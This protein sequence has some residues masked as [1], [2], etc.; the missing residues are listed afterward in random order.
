M[1]IIRS[2]IHVITN[3]FF[4]ILPW[5]LHVHVWPSYAGVYSGGAGILEVGRTISDLPSTSGC[6]LHTKLRNKIL[7]HVKVSLQFCNFG[8]NFGKIL[9]R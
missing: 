5:L 3:N 9:E 8:Y 6:L 7:M 1:H 2:G 4:I